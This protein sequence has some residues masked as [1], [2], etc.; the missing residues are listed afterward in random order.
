M[1]VTGT[2]QDGYFKDRYA[3]KAEDLVPDFSIVG[4]DIPFRKASEKIGGE[5]VEN[6]RVRRTAGFTFYS[7]ELDA[8]ALNPPISGQRKPA[9]IKGTQFVL[10]EQIATGVIKAA[11][12]SKEAFGNAFDDIVEDMMNAAGFAR[13]M[14]LLYGGSSIGALDSVSGASTTR[15]WVLT[16]ATWAAGL[17]AQFEGGAL[18]VYT[19]PG[20]TQR[21]T[22]AQVLITNI[23]ADT[24]T[25]SVSGNA[26]DLTACISGDVL[27]PY[28][29]D[30]MWSPGLD[31]LVPNTG[32]MH[33]I[34]AAVY[35]LWKGNSHAVGGA[36]SFAALQ[37]AGTKALVRG[38][39]GKVCVYMSPYTWEDLN[40]DAAALRRYASETKGELSLGT[41]SI[42]YYG[43]SGELEL[44]SHPM[45]KAGDAFGI[46]AKNWK[47][48]GSTDITFSLGVEGSQP[49]F[50]RELADNAGSEI[51]CYWNQGLMNCKPAGNFK[52][53]G[54]NN[55]SLS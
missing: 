8:F 48:P 53:T 5:F 27:I 29:A 37:S 30:E 23:D 35:G 44:K 33:G 7:S 32:S 46:K 45:V 14:Q 26:T 54:I 43:V 38:G 24:R 47:R 11:T 50:F 12:S 9:R 3:S 22:N 16:E 31:I 15:D 34:D 39:G 55:A 17:W 49:R 28:N 51:R 21:N 40:N 10:R 41:K 2:T 42:K 1:A 18:D 19:A 13:E 4:E 20:G 36:A 52:L 6:V 25:I